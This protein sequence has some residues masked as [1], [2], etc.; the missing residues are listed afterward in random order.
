MLEDCEL[1]QIRPTVIWCDNLSTI[2]ISKNPAH[3]GR[4]KHI[5]IRFH[6][7]RGLISDELIALKYCKTE[8]QL[9]DIF[10][11]PLTIQ[12]HSRLRNMLGMSNLQLRGDVKC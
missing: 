3:H 10:T 4:T 9:A 12:K 11:K 8:E 1:K 2:A 6:F 5:D 7:I